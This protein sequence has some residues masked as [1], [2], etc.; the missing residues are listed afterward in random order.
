MS[1]PLS[2]ALL[3]GALLF[4]AQPAAAAPMGPF[5]DPGARFRFDEVELRPY[6]LDGFD[7]YLN[8]ASYTPRLLFRWMWDDGWEDAAV[9]YTITAG[10]LTSDD[11]Y[12]DQRARVRLPFTDF[13]SA[14][15]E[16]V[17][18]EDF[19]GR[20]R[21]S[22]VQLLF[23]FFRPADRAPLTATPGWTPRAD[24]LFFG[25]T[26]V[27]D[28]FKE[29]ADIGWTLGYRN[30]WFGVRGDLLRPDYFFNVKADGEAEFSGTDPMTL[31]GQTW[32]ALLGGA[33][34]LHGWWVETLPFELEIPE[35]DALR[36]RWRKR[37]V[38]G[39]IAWHVAP[40]WRADLTVWGENLLRDKRE[41]LD[42]DPLARDDTERDVVRG[43]LQIEH[44][45][46]TL[47]ASGSL[48]ADTIL[49]GIWAQHLDERTER[50]LLPAERRKIVRR[51]EAYVDLAYVLA[52]PT[53]HQQVGWGVRL[54]TTT[55]FLSIRD[56]DPVLNR[57]RVSERFLSKINAG[58]EL[59]FRGGHGFAL[60][61]LTWFAS[62]NTFGGGNAQVQM[63]F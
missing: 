10:S 50:P 24:G 57:H 22:T 45:V 21:L 44:D 16:Y 4:A 42:S 32:F 49:F 2:L 61:Q 31:S 35:Q 1:R 33:L 19:D 9:G 13:L 3:A 54:G 34:R 58:L 23:R 36:L 56:V 5:P 26:G 27:L 46:P 6:D 63:T 17:E 59:H 12:V 37:R 51:G 15:Y 52:L 25:G 47:I 53:F 11:L 8:V 39:R 20:Y 14:Q 41:D 28:R 38:G 7:Y 60:L 29:F 18:S 30:N 55:G 48:P 62:D 40:G 43:L